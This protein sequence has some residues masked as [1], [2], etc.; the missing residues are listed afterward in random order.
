M[1]ST[2]PLPFEE[3]EHAA[4]ALEMRLPRVEERE[5]SRRRA[6]MPDHQDALRHDACHPAGR[7]ASR[8]DQHDQCA[9][10]GGQ[11]ADGQR[12]RADDERRTPHELEKS[13][14]RQ[15]LVDAASERGGF[16]LAPEVGHLAQFADRLLALEDRRARAG[17]A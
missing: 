4:E 17:A 16:Q 7:N 3:S 10:H 14:A 6:P 15:L 2:K 9:G 11:D 8:E 1:R 12:E 5:G 13:L